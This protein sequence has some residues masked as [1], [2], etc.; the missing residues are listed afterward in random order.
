MAKLKL[1]KSSLQKERDNLKLYRRLLPSLDLKRRQLTVEL[2]KARRQHEERKEAVDRLETRIGQE[3]PLMANGEVNLQGL[4]NMTGFQLGEENIVGT[5]LPI[6]KKIECQVVRYSFLTSPQ[7]VDVVVDRLREAAEERIQVQV[8][9]ERVRILQQAVRRITQRVNLF[10]RILIPAARK[11]IQRIRI[12][13]GDAERA[14][15]VRSKITKKK[16]LQAR[17]AATGG[18][19]S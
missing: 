3:I 17:S 14:A 16:Q 19:A 4:V 1:S 13:L 18:M 15:V 9:V 5:R 7:W 12:F 11:N 6:L 10:D 8:A 2:E